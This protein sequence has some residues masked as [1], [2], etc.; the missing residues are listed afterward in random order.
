MTPYAGG[1]GVCGVSA[2]EY[3]WAHGA[4]INFGL[5]ILRV[6]NI[7]PMTLMSLQLCELS[8]CVHSVATL[9]LPLGR[10]LYDKFSITYFKKQMK[11]AHGQ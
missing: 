10:E 2:N 6:L 1:W 11:I 4:Q 7:E 8:S 3:S 9:P 5:E